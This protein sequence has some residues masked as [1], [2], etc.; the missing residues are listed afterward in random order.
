MRRYHE[1]AN[2][3]CD[4]LVKRSTSFCCQKCLDRF[5]AGDEGRRDGATDH[6]DMCWRH[7]EERV[8]GPERRLL[9]R[10]RTER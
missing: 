10:E 9:E 5:E 1:C 7:Y 6:T 8:T 2:P 3:G 4:R